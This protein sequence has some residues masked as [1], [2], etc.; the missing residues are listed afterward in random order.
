TLTLTYNEALDGASD[1]VGNDYTITVNGISTTVSTVDANG[2]TVTLT[3]DNAISNGDTVTLNYTPG[4]TPVQD[5][6]GNDAI[7]LS[8]I[9]VTNNTAATGSGSS[10]ENF[11]LTY[12]LL[13]IRDAFDFTAFGYTYDQGYYNNFDVLP[14]EASNTTSLTTRRNIADM[15]QTEIDA[16]INAVLTL[17]NTMVVTDNG[18]EISIYDQFVAVH[19]AAADAIGRL[20]L[21]GETQVNPGHGDDSFLPWHRALLAEF[22][23]ALQLVDPNVFVP[24]WD[25]TDADE[26]WNEVF[27]DEVMGPNGGGGNGGVVQTGHFSTN[28]G[29]EVREDLVSAQWSGV[30]ANTTALTRN[31]GRNGMQIPGST[32]NIDA[33]LGRD[34]YDRFRAQVER[35]RGGHNNAHFF[36]GGMMS[37]VGGAPADPM[38]WLLHAN[39]D[40]LWAEWQLDG[41]WDDYAPDG[42]PYGHDVDDLMFLWDDGTFQIADDL[43]DLL[44]SKPGQGN[45][46]V[47]NGN[48]T[49]ANDLQNDGVVNP[50]NSPGIIKV[51]GDY[52]QTSEGELTIEITGKKPISEFDVLKIK[53]TAYLDGTLNIY[54]LDNVEPE[55]GIYKFLKASDIE[56]DFTT[57]NIYGLQNAY[58][59]QLHQHNGAYILKLCG[60]EE[61]SEAGHGIA[62]TPEDLQ[63][64]DNS[65]LYNPRFG[66]G[67]DMYG[68]GLTPH[69]GWGEEA[70]NSDGHNHTSDTNWFLPF[71]V[72]INYW[73]DAIAAGEEIPDEF[74]PP[75]EDHHG[76]HGNGGMGSGDDMNHGNHGDGGMDHGMGSGDDMNH[77]NH[78][79]GSLFEEIS[80]QSHTRNRPSRPQ[81]RRYRSRYGD[82][83]IFGLPNRL[84]GIDF[85]S[86]SS[87]NAGHQLQQLRSRKRRNH[88]LHKTPIIDTQLHHKWHNCL[89]EPFNY[90]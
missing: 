6:A 17:K 39:V 32:N 18:I 90:E 5:A 21:N 49:V 27:I 71:D 48:T 13:T 2:S 52:V 65:S 66:A 51:H 68:Y 73:L 25:W 34:D 77:G 22:E 74:L 60:L 76:E 4:T 58:D 57:I 55:L 82:S 89:I 59:Y 33:M 53:G 16:F 3:L 86:F 81:I 62:H 78:G 7:A 44:P 41:H 54:F 9:N 85:S 31:M 72:D 40:R 14:D 79:E 29:W 46:T 24:Y 64:I 11:T 15:T 42:Q 30:S 67:I 20:A 8:G 28:N 37:N 1:P 56:G 10:L 43:R 87:S 84:V 75:M 26:T 23:K 80:Y 61:E 88:F 70:L 38:F 12:D 63:E 45:S 69:H 35:A 36:I 50:G 47:V 83:D 19:V